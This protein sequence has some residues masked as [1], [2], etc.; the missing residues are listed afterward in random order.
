MAKLAFCGL[1]Q[2]GEPM[3]ARLIDAGHALAV[4]NRTRSRAEPLA[5][6]GAAVADSPADAARGA[7]AAIT[8][9]S[10]PAALDE[11]VFGEGGLVEGLSR[12]A[13]LIEMST[14][15]PQ[16]VRDAASRLP[17]DVAML[18]APVLG[19]TPAAEDGSLKILVGGERGEFERW[20]DV[21]EVLGSPTYLGELGAGAAM[22]LVANS[23]LGA[24]MTGLG[25]ALA[26]ADR[27]GIPQGLALDILSGGPFRVVI[28]RTRDAIE[29]GEYPPR[30]KL[31]LAEKDL[32]LVDQ[33]ARE[34]GLELRVAGAARSWFAEADAAG[35]G[36]LDYPAVIEHIRSS[37][38]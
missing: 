4:W 38:G 20:R 8:M 36:D 22:K 6:R 14:V 2:M 33:A 5:A 37:E 16:P 32:G 17:E 3:A 21:L 24:A 7:E 15:G 9:L 29:S 35:K 12:G 31:S 11:V 23:A 1:G 26:L 34:A 10:D 13:T 18:D 19:S 30:F 27:L 25:E 28:E